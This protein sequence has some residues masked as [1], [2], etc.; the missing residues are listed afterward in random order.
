MAR[1]TKMLQSSTTYAKDGNTPKLQFFAF[2]YDEIKD[3]SHKIT[4]SISK[5]NPSLYTRKEGRRFSFLVPEG[6]DQ[7]LKAILKE[8]KG[9]AANKGNNLKV[10]ESIEEW[11][12]RV[13]RTRKF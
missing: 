10:D 8:M 13:Y 5:D 4:K 11:H 1:Q 9:N 12:K 3:E 2:S 6:F 7:Q